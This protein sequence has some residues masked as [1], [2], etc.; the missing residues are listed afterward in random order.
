MAQWT[1]RLPTEQEIGGS[2]PSSCKVTFTVS[3]FF[4][5]WRERKTSLNFLA[6][7]I[8]KGM[9]KL[10]ILYLTSDMHMM[11]MSY[12]DPRFMMTAQLTPDMHMDVQDAW[13]I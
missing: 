9:K 13:F 5:T 1:R 3:H 4:S 12:V 6:L 11:H 8:Y 10:H 2:S 7:Q